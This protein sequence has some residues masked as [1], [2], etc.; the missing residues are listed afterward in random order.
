MKS[1]IVRLMP[2]AAVLAKF[3]LAGTLG[4]VLGLTITFAVVSRGQG[5]A[6]IRAGPWTGWPRNEAA[7]DIDP[8]TRAILARSGRAALNESEA[9]GFFAKGDSTGSEFDPACEYTIKGEVP[10]ARHWTLT[11][12]TPE[13]GLVSNQTGRQGLTSNELLRASDGGFEIILSRKARAG[14]WLQIGDLPRFI[15]VL[16]F[17]DSELGSPATAIDAAH[18]PAVI[19]GDC[20]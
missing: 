16:R 18:M 7:A 20:R 17:Y 1:L 13:G 15:I 6:A 19:R 4:I 9:V 3:A 12:F 10:A 11:L 5:F 2:F 14:N 8:Y